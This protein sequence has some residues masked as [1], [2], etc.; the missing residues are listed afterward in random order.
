MCDGPVFQAPYGESIAGLKTFSVDAGS[1]RDWCWCDSGGFE[2]T[3]YDCL[4]KG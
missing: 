4:E 2:N 3:G 1:F